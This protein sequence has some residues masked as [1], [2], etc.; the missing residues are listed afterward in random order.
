[1]RGGAQGPTA[2]EALVLGT[3]DLY[4]EAAYT[5]LSRARLETRVYL[6]ADDLDDDP[7]VDLSHAVRDRG[8]RTPESDLALSL[9]RSRSDHLAL[10]R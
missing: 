8:G 7:S 2:D 6:V 9:N 1:M 10:D 4:Q 5:A 3:D